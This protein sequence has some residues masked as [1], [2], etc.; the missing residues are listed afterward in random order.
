MRGSRS[1]RRCVRYFPV[2]RDS[3]NLGRNTTFVGLRRGAKRPVC[4]RSRRSSRGIVGRAKTRALFGVEI[5]TT[6][7]TARKNPG[8]REVCG[9][10]AVMR[11]TA[12]P[13]ELVAGVNAMTPSNRSANG[14]SRQ[15]R[16]LFSLV[17]WYSAFP[18]SGARG[19][20]EPG[21]AAVHGRKYAWKVS[22]T[23]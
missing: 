10:P 19:P 9:C 11:D 18:I 12:R 22:S 2:R 6:I 4:T 5:I 16:R 7:Q 13:R 8:S 3:V 20:H 23:F 15:A 14:T 21:H 1:G 17:D